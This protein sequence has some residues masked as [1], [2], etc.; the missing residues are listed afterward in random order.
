M[1]DYKVGLISLGCPKNQIDSEIM[2]GKLLSAG[3]HKVDEIEEADIIIINTCA[4]IESAKK[5]A[6]ETILEI[7]EYKNEGLIKAIVVTG[8]L[9]ERYRE[10]VINEMPEIDAVIGIGANNDIVDVCLK[11]LNGKKTSLFPNKCNL[12]LSGK[13]SLIGQKFE[14]YIKISDGC[15]NF[16]SFCAIPYIRGKYRERPIED[17]VS[18]AET[19]AKEGVRELIIVAQDT[20]RYGTE[21]YGKSSIHILLRELCKIDGIKWI[22]LY[23]CYPERITDELIDTIAEEDK[24]CSYIDIPIQ[25]CSIDVLKRMNR[26]GDRESLKNLIKKIRSKIPNVAIRS[27]LMVGFP[28]ETE[29]DFEE[30]CNF[31]KEI[32]FDK[33]GCFTFSPEEGTK[34]F[35]MQDQIDEEVKERRAEILNDIQFGITEKTNKRKIGQIYETLTEDFQDGKYIG[36]AYFDSPEI[37][38]NIIFTSEKQIN[39]GSFVDVQITGYEGYDL[40][41]KVVLGG[42]FNEFTK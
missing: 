18:E 7:A 5:Q 35:N 1:N 20:T 12:P 38:S 36:R 39:I 42:T 25:H 37:D 28:G 24:I 32:E 19:L 41:G 23:Y 15:N 14:A 26:N 40:I 3:F 8:C 29:K 6:I 31:V 4:F 17:I 16:C 30:L 11:A 22:R 21:I 10:E 9:S 27:T 34:A 2:L 33:M 13:R